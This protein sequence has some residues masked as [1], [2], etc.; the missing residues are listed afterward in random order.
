MKNN[1]FNNIYGTVDIEI[2][3]IKLE[4]VIEFLAERVCLKNIKRKSYTIVQAQTNSIGIY[5]IRK[6]AKEISGVKIKVLKQDHFSRFI[7]GMYRKWWIIAGLVSVLIL[8]VLIS[9]MCLSI[10]V[11]G[12]ETVSEIEIF[13]VLRD[14]GIKNFI[15][16]KNIDTQLIEKTLYKEINEISYTDVKFDGT[17]LIIT[18]DER[19]EKPLIKSDEPSSL[20]ADKSGVVENIVVRSGE[21]KVEK[22]DVVHEGDILICGTYVKNDTEFITAADGD[23]W[24]LTDYNGTAYTD[25]YP[26]E[27]KYTGKISRERF[28][29]LGNFDIKISGKNE[30]DSFTSSMENKY[31]I[32]NNYP[33]SIK[34][35]DVIYRE[36]IIDE[37]KKLKES[38]K[39]E[40]I[41]KAYYSALKNIPDNAIIT[42]FNSYIVYN[43]SEVK[44]FAV[45]T[46]RENIGYRAP[47]IYDA[48][49]KEDIG[50]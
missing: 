14:N 37:P 35:Y 4:K 31:Q 32:L 27:T 10:D 7:Y 26:Y 42:D 18:I 3:G 40:L 2:I 29:E 36:C 45:I 9:N 48:E 34:I 49:D 13:D 20:I 15:F 5:K 38:I 41:E 30:F 46:T 43:D 8:C 1:R 33:G 16:K 47:V 23:I 24:I 28:L 21:A 39:L 6:Y 25:K 50:R 19:Y 22:G 11:F 12:M 44:A 17:R